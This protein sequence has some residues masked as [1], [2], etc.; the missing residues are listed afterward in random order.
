M[1][2]PCLQTTGRRVA[3]TYIQQYTALTRFLLY[4][5]SKRRV[6]CAVGTHRVTIADDCV[7]PGFHSATNIAS[8]NA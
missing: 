4:F 5:L 7:P 6:T 1:F 2:I 3:E 8:V